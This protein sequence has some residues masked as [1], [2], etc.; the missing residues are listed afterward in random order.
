M[1][2]LII[3]L[4]VFSLPLAVFAVIAKI[5]GNIFFKLMFRIGG[6]GMLTIDIII[7]L[8]LNHII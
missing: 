6:I 2:T 8:K 4:I 1:N 5:T 7:L 3:L